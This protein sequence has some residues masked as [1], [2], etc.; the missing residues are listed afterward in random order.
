MN[1][2]NEDFKIAKI[3]IKPLRYTLMELREMNYLKRKGK[4]IPIELLK[5]PF[6]DFEIGNQLK[7]RKSNTSIKK[8]K[9]EKINEIKEENPKEDSKSDL[10]KS[11]KIENKSKESSNKE[12]RQSGILQLKL[13]GDEDEDFNSSSND[14]NNDNE[15]L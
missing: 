4:P 6:E 1:S 10:S 14:S 5:K 13:C 11:E 7:T 2:N 15:N 8:L 12:S 3:K 9:I